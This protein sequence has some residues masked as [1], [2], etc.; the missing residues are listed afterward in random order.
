MHDPQEM[1]WL[2]AEV[3]RGYCVEMSEWNENMKDNIGAKR[4]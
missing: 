3:W 2:I 4:T 1:V